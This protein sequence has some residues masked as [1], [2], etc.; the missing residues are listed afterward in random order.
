MLV[1]DGAKVMLG[2]GLWRIVDV[3][4]LGGG[5]G[6]GVEGRVG[7]MVVPAALGLS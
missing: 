6:C 2:T 1:E 3:L 4:W 5:I 7:N